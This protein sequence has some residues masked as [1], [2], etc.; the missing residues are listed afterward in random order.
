MAED[1]FMDRLPAPG[2]RHRFRREE[3]L[4]AV[5][6]RLCQR[7]ARHPRKGRLVPERDVHAH[8]GLRTLYLLLFIACIAICENA[9]AADNA[10][11]ARE[12]FAKMPESIFESTAEGLDDKDKQDLLNCGRS[13][14][15]GKLFRK[16]LT[17]WFFQI[18]PFGEKTMGLRLFRK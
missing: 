5:C 3:W 6:S 15:L 13:G 12:I 8:G 9:A 2:M 18:C 17:P 10:V 1:F 7:A 14:I 11:T 4:F 16:R